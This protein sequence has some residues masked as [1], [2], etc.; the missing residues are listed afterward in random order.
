[1]LCGSTPHVP[2]I[3]V[4]A[5]PR[6]ACKS[7][8]MG[9]LQITRIWAR[10]YPIFEREDAEHAHSE[11]ACTAERTLA[12]PATCRQY[13]TSAEPSA[14]CLSHLYLRKERTEERQCRRWQA[15]ESGEPMTH[16]RTSSR[17]ALVLRLRRSVCYVHGELRRAKLG[18]RH[19]PLSSEPYRTCIDVDARRQGR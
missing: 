17:P 11:L 16:E 7:R 18:A 19:R 10:A 6:D 5:I 13:P 3:G 1:M 2:R 14:R 12:W 9:A 8:T 15:C 4:K